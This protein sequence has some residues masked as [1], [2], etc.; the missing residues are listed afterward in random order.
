MSIG[1]QTTQVACNFR[2]VCSTSYTSKATNTCLSAC[3][4]AGRKSFCFPM[5]A[6]V[7]IFSFHGFNRAEICGIGGSGW[8]ERA[9]RIKREN[10]AL[11]FLA[12]ST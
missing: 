11:A 5:V 10:E 9:I 1:Y 3:L 2:L 4:A 12:C 7:L 6:D 8:F